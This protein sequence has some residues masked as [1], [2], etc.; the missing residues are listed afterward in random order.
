MTAR[1][2]KLQIL[3][4]A[5]L[6]SGTTIGAGMLGLPLVTAEA[7]F[8]PG[9]GITLIVWLFML[10]TGLLFLE[11][12]LWCKE[13]ANILTIG[14]AYLGKVGRYV[15]GLFF[16]FLYYCL[17]IAYFAAGGALFHQFVQLLFS[18]MLSFKMALFVFG[19]IFSAI[20]AIGPRS[21]D[22]ANVLLSL[23]MVAS[24]ILLLG[25]GVPN[26]T[27]E[28][29]SFFNWP[30]M[31]FAAPVI[32]SAF[33]YH[34]I[35]P[36]LATHLKRDRKGLIASIV[37]GTILPLIVYL[38]WQWLIIGAIPQSDLH[39]VIR[40][41]Q[42]VTLALASITNNTFVPFFGDCFAFFAIVTSVLGVSFSMVDFMSDGLQVKGEGMFRFLLT[43]LVYVPPF[44]FAYTVPG[45]FSTALGIAGGIGE[46]FLNGIFPVLIV[47]I[48]RYRMK[49]K[50]L[51]GAL[52]N[53]FI[54]AIL[55]AMSI[56]V[57]GLELIQLFF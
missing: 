44:F 21:I 2:S 17:M 14:D 34:N 20:V 3:R 54:L 56:A 12:T 16:V 51:V 28:R 40:L 52:G 5:L 37:I 36:S 31:P 30:L 6:I 1:I 46:T 50:P 53:P 10:A 8:L 22:R 49:E 41:G 39:E 33:G 18:E 9:I 25:V 4:G 27:F 45:I 38:L 26:I 48:G 11:G 32:F 42:P 55:L 43:L 19:A 57:F 15:G 29:L 35:I 47:Y 23:G 13:G 24:W 7:G